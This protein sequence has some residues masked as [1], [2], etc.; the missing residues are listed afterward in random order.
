MAPSLSKPTLFLA[1]LAA[2]SFAIPAP[3]A[4][5]TVVLTPTPVATPSASS[6]L[7]CLNNASNGL[8]FQAQNSQ[9]N[10]VCS[11]D[12]AGGDMGMSNVN[13]F[14]ACV[15]DCDTTAGCVDVSFVWPNACYK[16]NVLTTATSN[17][18]VWTAKKVGVSG[19]STSTALSCENNRSNGAQYTT[20]KGAFQVVCGVD[21]A[22]GDLSSSHVASFEAC[23]DD[24]ASTTGCIDVS[25]VY[26]ACYKKSVLNSNP[27]SVASVWTAKL[28]TAQTAAIACP[29]SNGASASISTGGTYDILCG[30][31]YAGGDMVE[32]DT[33]SFEQC[34]EACDQHSGC[35]AVSYVAPSC[36]LKKTLTTPVAVSYVW[37]A[38]KRAPTVC[39]A[40]DGGVFT[41]ATRANTYHI[42]CNYDS[43]GMDLY[44]IVLPSFDDCMNHCSGETGCVGVS[45][46]PHLTLCW[47]KYYM[48]TQAMFPDYYLGFQVW[49][50]TRDGH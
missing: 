15:R 28:V 21:Y 41:D 16:K 42:K 32:V 5:S 37:G 50:G 2:R 45:W 43:P 23:I 36:Y 1:L 18:A 27:V 22:G 26:G 14:E 49:L 3:V 6:T 40:A 44:S 9:W 13:S 4:T 29:T 46:V 24:C 8:T 20:S 19:A 31:D 30:T 12:Y 7:S 17:S 10:I 33:T 11:T 35:L 34:L 47:P 38:V 25:Y 39:P 48:P